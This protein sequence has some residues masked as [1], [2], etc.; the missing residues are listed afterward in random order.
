MQAAPARPPA[1]ASTTGRRLSLI[2]GIALA[3]VAFL[4]IAG[5]GVYV[6]Q[7]SNTGNTTVVVAARDIQPRESITAD[8]VTTTTI[9]TSGVQPG[10]IFKISD[11]KHSAAAALILKGQQISKNLLFDE[12]NLQTIA[13]GGYLPIPKGLV[14]VQIPTGEIQGVGGFPEAGDYINVIVNV[15]QSVFP[16]L[17]TAPENRKHAD[18]SK[19]V[20]SGLKIIS[21]GP[22]GK[23]NAQGVSS[24]L[25]VIMSQCDAEYWDWLQS[26]ARVT[27]QLLSYKDYSPGPATPDATCPP[28]SQKGVG[29]NQVD[30]RF[31]FTKI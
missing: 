11:L 27:Y 8:M 5:L 14:A 30:G 28:T 9:P 24:S 15:S 13:V 31:G 26:N 21:V 29:P 20:I 17:N 22:A 3:V 16:Q 1:T 12:S 23:T 2:L 25:T 4:G 18:V 6:T 10:A 7:Q 19:T